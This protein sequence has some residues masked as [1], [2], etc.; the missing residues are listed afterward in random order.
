[1]KRIIALFVTMFIAGAAFADMITP[2]IGYDF[3]GTHKS[4][5]GSTST[6]YDTDPGITIGADYIHP[7]NDL[8]AFGGG[9]EYQL[10]RGVDVNVASV[11]PAFSFLPIYATGIVTPFK[12][13]L[14]G[15]KPYGKLNLGY[16]ILSGNDD[17]KGDNTLSGG[18][19]WALG[20]GTSYKNFFGELLYSTNTGQAKDSST[21][22][23][24]YTKLSL[25]IGYQFDLK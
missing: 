1:M 16:D 10:A 19:Y 6:D 4:E 20:V 5:A 23:I 22:D 8:F 2:K 18:L 15:F 3:A 11:D 13:D 12:D 7:V 25:N 14:N 9:F 24:T 17:Y 21:V